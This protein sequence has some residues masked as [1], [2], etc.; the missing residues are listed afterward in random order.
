ME[1][2]PAIDLRNGNAVRLVQGD[3]DQMTV[4]SPDPAA[5]ALEFKKQGAKNLHVVDLDGAKDAALANFSTIRRL[6]EETDLFVE[7]GGGIRSEKAI[8]TYL[9]LGAGRVILGTVAVTNYPFLEEMV[10]KYG[11]KI[12]VGVDAK[13]GYVATHGWL[14]TSTLKGVDFCRQLKESGVKTVI[15]TDISRDGRMQ[16][17][18]LALYDELSE[19]K[20]LNIVASG[21]IS[22]LEEIVKLKNK[23]YGAILGKALYLGAIDLAEALKAA[24]QA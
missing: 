10:K 1:L 17:T 14:E 12:A 15:Y 4:F 13:D 9:S 16:G 11:D 2:F 8:D 24:G 6:I 19:I 5:V 20:G 23:V 21:G 3:Y 22:S 18:N 7:V